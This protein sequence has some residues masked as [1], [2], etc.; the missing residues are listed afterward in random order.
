M[1]MDNILKPNKKELLF[2]NIAYERFFQLCDI[3]TNDNFMTFSDSVRLFYIKEIIS[4]YTELLNYEPIKYV[5]E[6]LKTH[7]PPMEAELSSELLK[8]IRNVLSH[9]PLFNSWNDIWINTDMCTWN[10]KD[11]SILKFLKKYSKHG[12]I[13]YRIWDNQKKEMTYLD[14]NFTF[15]ISS[16]KIYLKDILEEKSGVKFLVALMRPVLNSQ[17]EK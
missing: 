10:K 5:I 17:L 15:D 16:S 6:Y 9:F 4:L 7:R 3:I 2:L 12:Q 14:I 13:K 8:F 1:N 11:G